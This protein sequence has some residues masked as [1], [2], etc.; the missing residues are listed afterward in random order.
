MAWKHLPTKRSY[1]SALNDVLYHQ[2]Q[3]QRLWWFNPYKN[4]LPVMFTMF[5]SL[6]LSFRLM[7]TYDIT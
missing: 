1:F 3:I 6:K 5:Y 2:L 7:E 4:I